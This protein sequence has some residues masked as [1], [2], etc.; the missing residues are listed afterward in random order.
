MARPCQDQAATQLPGCYFANAVIWTGEEFLVAGDGP[1]KECTG[2]LW[3]SADGTTWQA[4]TV[5]LGSP[6]THLAVSP[7][8]VVVGGWGRLLSAP[9]AAAGAPAPD[10]RR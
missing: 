8:T 9:V 4:E 7:D 3:A 2:R 10:R 1:C 6:L 5:P